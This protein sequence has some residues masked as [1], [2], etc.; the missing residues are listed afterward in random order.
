VSNDAQRPD[1]LPE[2]RHPPLNEVV[3]G[4]Q[5][6]PPNGYQQI[7]AG[8]VWDLFR[9]E[10]PTVVEQPPLPP[11]FETFGLPSMGRQVRFITGPTHTRF[12]FLN[13]DGGE[14]IQFQQ[15]RFLH[16]WRKDGK[17]TNE[18]PRFDSLVKR[19][20]EELSQL[21]N[22]TNSLKPQSL[23]INQC[24]ISY[25]NH[26][27]SSPEQPLRASD[28]LRF[29]P[30]ENEPEDFSVNYREVIHDNDGRPTGRLIYNV[31]LGLKPDGQRIIILTLTVRGA[32]RDA[33][34]DSAV[35]FLK[36]GRDRIVTRF[37]EVTTGKAHQQWERIK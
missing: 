18:Y 29:V 36:M 5:F 26:I 35:E 30:F 23:L 3:L 33:S 17:E 8:E 22:Y 13:Q 19:F 2:F 10:F 37:A 24:E 25:I 15:D 27:A 4:V 31:A 32:T 34:I 16:N 12:W 21:Q 1:H 11:V 7:Y 6:N 9:Q 14:L 20:Y 28:W